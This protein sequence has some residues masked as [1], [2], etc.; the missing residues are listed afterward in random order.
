MI[1]SFDTKPAKPIEMKGVNGMPTPVKASVPIIIVQ[2]VNGIS[3][4]SPPIRRMSC[5]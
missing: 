4:R 3:V 2:N 5:S 1:G